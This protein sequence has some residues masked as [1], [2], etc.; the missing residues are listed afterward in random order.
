LEPTSQL[1]A[2]EI[3]TH[4][5]TTNLFPFFPY[6]WI[7]KMTTDLKE[8]K[9][10]ETKQMILCCLCG[11]SM[12]SNPANM[13]LSCI[14]T[15]V[16]ITENLSKSEI[17]I[18][19]KTCERYLQPP[20]YWVKCGL[21]SKEL[22]TVC[23]KKIKGLSK[24]K[25]VDAIFQW[26]EPHSRRVKVRLTI[27]KEIFNGAKLQQVCDV[28]FVVKT[29]Q[30]E[31]CAKSFT[32]H[33]WV[34][35]VQVRQKVSHKKTFYYLE[36]VILKHKAHQNCIGIKERSNGLDFYF[37]H[38]NAAS[39]FND[40][41]CG[42]TPAT[43]VCAKRL[44]THDSHNNSYQY[45]YSFS[46]EIAPICHQDL[47]C[48][49]KHFH[50]NLGGI[51]PLVMC[52]KVNQSIHLMDPVTLKHAEIPG[53]IYWKN[54][55]PS[56]MT[57][58]Q[59]EQFFV[60]DIDVVPG[61][62]RYGKFQLAEVQV[63]RPEDMTNGVNNVYFVKT[64]LGKLLQVGDIV[65]GYDL[66]GANTNDPNFP[67][68][69]SQKNT[70]S[71]QD[72]YLVKK[73]YENDLK[74][75]KRNWKLKALKKQQ[76]DGELKKGEQ[77]RA[78]KDYE[79]FLNEI[80]E[81]SDLRKD[82]VLYKSS[83]RPKQ[84]SNPMSGDENIVELTNKVK[85]GKGLRRQIESQS[86]INNKGVNNTGNKPPT[87]IMKQQKQQ[88][89]E[90]EVEL[91]E[92][93]Q[94]VDENDEEGEGIGDEELVDEEDLEDEEGEQLIDIDDDDEAEGEGEFYTADELKD[95]EDDSSRPVSDEIVKIENNRKHKKK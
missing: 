67:Q 45:K 10:D 73:Y 59:L 72:I 9:K 66:G 36:Q 91:S 20:K 17:L 60:I 1:I 65:L 61:V 14:K 22:L 37:A 93:D 76:E 33:K 52:T 3:S 78:E 51:G 4:D 62:K 47:I 39:K 2:V 71:F 16:D 85:N 82:I 19:C 92:Q 56:L 31:A 55:F 11:I 46:T 32:P 40:F 8:N 84:Q 87:T 25:L 29:Q 74:K 53:F 44:V 34:A 77:D 5:I 12:E 26:T 68:Y 81:F 64:H 79:E 58:K 54:K 83:S 57:T 23:L 6:F 38:R 95:N 70:E 30:C 89:K 43:F 90:E 86:S 24:V 42:M 35:S 88:Q 63:C 80:E 49:P 41:I 15:Q 13:C 50:K 18:F 48:L 75:K 69:H 94:D 21:E 28:D 27:Q 7:P